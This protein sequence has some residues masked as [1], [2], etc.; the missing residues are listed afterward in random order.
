[1]LPVPPLPAAS[2]SADRH[3]RSA[4]GV[5]RAGLLKRFIGLDL[6][7]EDKAARFWVR[8]RRVCERKGRNGLAGISPPAVPA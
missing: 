8:K 5:A 2:G 6:L 1:M 7:I 3:F 4:M